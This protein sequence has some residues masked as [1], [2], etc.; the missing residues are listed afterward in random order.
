MTAVLRTK[1]YLG[2]TISEENLTHIY[3]KAVEAQFWQLKHYL[4]FRLKSDQTILPWSTVYNDWQKSLNLIAKNSIK[5]APGCITVFCKDLLEICETFEGS[6]VK[7]SCEELYNEFYQRNLDK[8]I[9]E[10]IR[11][12]DLTIFS[13]R[14]LSELLRNVSSKKRIGEDNEVSSSS[15]EKRIRHEE[16]NVDNVPSESVCT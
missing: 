7:Q 12:L 5:K 9:S 8:Q 16:Y 13:K 10:R 6:A 15:S 2:Y 11:Q 3:F 1:T 4:W 14:K